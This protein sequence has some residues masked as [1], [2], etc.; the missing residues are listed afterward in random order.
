MANTR[1]LTKAERK[2]TKRKARRA[3]KKLF[4]S[5]SRKDR[6]EMARSEKTM[7]GYLKEKGRL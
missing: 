6:S 1:N 7:K 4:Q 5:L 3:N 2:S